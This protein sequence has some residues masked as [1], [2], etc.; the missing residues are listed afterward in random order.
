MTIDRK[1]IDAA[2]VS[3]LIAEQFPK[4]A[5]LPV[6]PVEFGGWDNRTFHLGDS[7]TV[8]LPSA[9]SYA[10]QVEK[11]QRWLPKLAPLLPLPIPTP[12]AKGEPTDFYPGR[13]RSTGGST[14]RPL[15]SHASTT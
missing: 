13:G 8:R 5:G 9:A 6:R 2:L 12:L 10:A 3:R 15:R 4:W 14:A 11:E 7:M 1:D